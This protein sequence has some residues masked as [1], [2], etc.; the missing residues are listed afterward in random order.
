MRRGVFAAVCVL[1]LLAAGC[2]SAANAEPLCRQAGG[3]PLVLMQQALPEATYLPCLAALPE[4]WG[5]AGFDVTPGR[6][7]MVLHVGAVEAGH[8]TITV[9]LTAACA[10]DA[11]RERPSGVDGVRRFDHVAEPPGRVVVTR[12]YRFDGGCVQ[13]RYDLQPRHREDVLGRSWAVLGLV[14]AAEVSAAVEER[15]GRAPTR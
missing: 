2:A 3:G 8:G 1:A 4:A 5:I 14:P 12:T 9:T 15:Y 6:A 10:A 11:G 7:R 13:E